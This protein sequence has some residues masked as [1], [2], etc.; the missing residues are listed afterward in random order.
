M[1]DDRQRRGVENG[2]KVRSNTIHRWLVVVRHDRHRR[3][4]AGRL[5]H[6]RPRDRASRTI[7]SGACDDPQAA[8]RDA[9]RGADQCHPLAVGQRIAFADGVADDDGGGASADLTFAEAGE[10][11]NIEPAISMKGRR[12]ISNH[13]MEPVMAVT[14]CVGR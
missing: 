8:A 2:V 1:Q 10:S 11:E 4:G 7:R 13:A 12:Q 3:I 6:P 14:G 9:D 5:R